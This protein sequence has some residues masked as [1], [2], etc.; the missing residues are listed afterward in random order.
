M[1]RILLSLL[2]TGVITA[3]LISCRKPTEEDFKLTILKEVNTLREEGCVC[4]EDTMPPVQEIIW[5]ESLEAAAKLHVSDMA[6]HDFLSHYGT[7]GS[8]PY[9]RSADAGFEGAFIGENI[10]RGYATIEDVMRQWRN[11]E[12]HCKTMMDDHYYFM[13]VAIEDYYWVQIFGSN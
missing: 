6:E 2:L 8:T 13:A 11:S 5:D 1:G 10:A 3:L 7:D 4:G 12:N 9:Q